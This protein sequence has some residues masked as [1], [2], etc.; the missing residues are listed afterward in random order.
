M[1]NTSTDA[2]LRA[3]QVHMCMH[4]TLP[5]RCPVP[6]LACVPPRLVGAGCPPG[7]RCAPASW[8]GPAARRRA[9]LPA[10]CTGVQNQAGA[11]TNLMHTC[12]LTNALQTLLE[13]AN[14]TGSLSFYMVSH[15]S[16]GRQRRR[17]GGRCRSCAWPRLPACLPIVCATEVTVQ[18][19]LLKPK[20]RHCRFFSLF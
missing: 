1:A 13:Y 5:S 20:V 10:G 4:A 17:R 8:L 16:F 19:L 3:T 7:C 6:C 14:S 9:L 18:T 2:L 11:C 15:R 12:T